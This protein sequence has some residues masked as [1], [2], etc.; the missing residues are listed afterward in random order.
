MV[1]F[2]LTKHL[3]VANGSSLCRVISVSKHLHSAFTDCVTW[4]V[5]HRNRTGSNWRNYLRFNFGRY[6]GLQWWTSRTNYGRIDANNIA[7]SVHVVRVNSRWQ[8]ETSTVFKLILSS[9]SLRSRNAV[10][11]PQR[12]GLVVTFVFTVILDAVPMRPI[13]ASY[14]V[15][16]YI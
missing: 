4:P 8:H 3:R 13:S 10:L 5:G 9:E 1:L 14:A 16:V 15:T 11:D 6:V 12:L 2:L 7:M